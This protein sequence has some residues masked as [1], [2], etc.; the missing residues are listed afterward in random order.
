MRVHVANDIDE[1]LWLRRDPRA[2]AQRIFWFVAAGDVVVL[3]DRPDTAFVEHVCAVRGIDPTTIRVHV[4]P[5]GAHEG[6]RL[7]P[8]SLLDP[9][10]VA[11]VAAGLG[12]VTEVTGLF[13]STMVGEFADRLGLPDR[14]PGA[15]FVAQGGGHLANSKA[16]FRAVAAGVGAPTA[17]GY[18]CSDPAEAANA[19]TQLIDSGRDVL[20]KKAQNGAGAGNEMVLKPGAVPPDNIGVRHV[21]HLDGSPDAVDRYWAQRW[22]WASV[23]NRFPVLVEQ[24]LDVRDSLYVELQVTAQG[25][26]VC[27]TGVLEFTDGMISRET[28][29]LSEVD[30]KE[31]GR[32]VANA[33]RVADV[34]RAMGYRGY[35]CVDAVL[36]ADGRIV[37]T[38]INARTTTS[39]HLYQLMGF[40]PGGLRTDGGLVLRQHTAPPSWP[41]LTTAQFLD[42]VAAAGVGYH[43]D[44]GGVFLS[45]PATKG[46][47]FGLVCRADEEPD[48]LRA[49]DSVFPRR[50]WD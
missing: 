1:S 39:S 27:A 32:F 41:D 34:F 38:E 15:G 46:F 8:R 29:G 24:L 18:V 23:D 6:R 2:W 14:V 45:M 36:T 20:V 44:R 3:S 47:F 33:S 9:G 42:R 30:T 35:F 28:L 49:I 48:H 5:P 13:P 17:P 25:C 22:A 10:F 7:E 21:H 43:P 19:M 16:T 31:A 26:R 40:E 4:A 11:E 12:E 50:K 37:L